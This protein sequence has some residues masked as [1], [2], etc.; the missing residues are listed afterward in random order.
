MGSGGGKE[1]KELRG[2]RERWE[3]EGR[4]GAERV[5]KSSEERERQRDEERGWER[6]SR[7]GIERW[8]EKKRGIG[9]E[10]MGEWRTGSG[11]WP[12]SGPGT[13]SH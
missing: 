8:D 6:G 9:E 1:F 2:G 7:K 5:G 12:R 13:L 11:Q 3:G 10:A 4:E